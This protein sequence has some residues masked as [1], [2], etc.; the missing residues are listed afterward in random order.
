MK[1]I[2]LI[3][4]AK[5]DVLAASAEAEALSR[6]I[7]E[8][9]QLYY[10][11]DAPKISDAE[12]DTLRVRLAA[13]EARF[14]HLR[15]GDS[16][17]DRVGAAPAAGFAK[18]AHGAPMLSLDNAFSE[19]DAGDFLNRARR[20]LR[21]EADTQITLTA[22]PKIDGLSLSL[23]YVDGE[24]VVAAT[25]GDG[26]EGEDVTANAR[27][28]A[29]IP[30]QLHADGW[31]QRI[32]IRG[33]V[34][35]PTEAFGALNARA[36]AEGGQIF[37]N[38]R[39]AAA[40]AL[41]QFDPN[42]TASRP[43]RFFAYAWG[44]SS[45]VFAQ[46]QT[47][48]MAQFRAWGLSTNPD[49][50]R[51]ETLA[52][53]LAVYADLAGRR[54]LLGYDV[55]G[56]VYKIDEIAL[57]E[58]LGFAGRA[59]RWAIAHKFPAQQAQTVLEAIEIQV[60]RTGALT[61]VA[62]LKPV[63]VG[64]VVVAN[65]TLH[66]EDEI[67]R[68][69]LRIGDQVI[70]QRAGDVI[71][72]I[73][74][75][76]VEKRPADAIKFVFPDHCP[77]CGAPAPRDPDPKGGKADA[78]RR[79]SNERNCPAQMVERLKHFVSRAAL[80]I[81]GLGAKQIDALF[82]DGIVREPGDIFT[83]EDRHNR[84]DIDLLARDGVGET[85][86]RNLFAAIEARRSV[87][88]AKFLFALGIRHVGE[89]TAHLLAQHYKSWEV[90]VQAMQDAADPLHPAHGELTAI[91][92]I[93]SASA[94]A[95][96]LYFSAAHNLGVLTRLIY[97]RDNNPHGI[98]IREVEAVAASSPIAGKTLV[99]TGMLETMSRDEAKAQAQKLG[100]KVAGAV[101]SKTD[102][103]IAGPGAGSKLKQA[104]AIG[105]TVISEQEWRGLISAHA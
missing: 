96:T 46:T 37:A 60:G 42:I 50:R 10:Q 64:G 87:P 62:R 25:R 51:C 44:A 88:L 63:N 19:E 27:T 56:V 81:D 39:N 57:Q 1:S 92:G 71:P 98:R 73:L 66:N 93:G 9:D 21:L 69:D 67:A 80:D 17:S 14:P 43:L 18:V 55:D 23:T 52:Q 30:Q 83:L 100:A 104:E 8:H 13:I 105:V 12:Y 79:C 94:N 15:L 82:A 54:A 33:E 89:Q 16:P 99:F 72:Q 90:F 48:A 85:S 36:E 68:K 58:R 70:V 47:A 7:I 6:E 32:E 77:A 76:V 53:A 5:L 65:A 26:R 3:D 84:G 2:R 91:D 34:Y 4:V 40:G 103:V 74:G 11:N 24:L 75:V 41:R 28:I 95:I 101:S 97:T 102:L 31:P 22:E 20:F 45:A 86:L 49:F 38:P 78:V 35:M 59:P 61:P 29:D